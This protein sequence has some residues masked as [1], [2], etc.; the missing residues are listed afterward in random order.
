M[1][2][3]TLSWGTPLPIMPCAPQAWA[4]WRTGRAFPWTTTPRTTWSAGTRTRASTSAVRTSWTAS[5]VCRHSV[6]D[7]LSPLIHSYSQRPSDSHA[8]QFYLEEEVSQKNHCTYVKFISRHHKLRKTSLSSRRSPLH[9]STQHL[10]VAHA[11]S[12]TLLPSP[13]PPRGLSIS[14][15]NSRCR[16]RGASDALLLA[17]PLSGGVVTWEATNQQVPQTHIHPLLDPASVPGVQEFEI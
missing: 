2:D 6:M 14:P 15:L 7:G 16:N 5:T 9:L 10:W 8:V 1:T 11:C 3:N 17:A 12:I 13:P 4:T